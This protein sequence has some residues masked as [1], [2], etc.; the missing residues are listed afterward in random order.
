MSA[1][2]RNPHHA[3]ALADFYADRDPADVLDTIP[4]AAFYV[5]AEDSCMSGWGPCDGRDGRPWSNWVVLPCA[6]HNE[7][8]RVLTYAKSRGEMKRAR[9]VRN[10]PRQRRGVLMSVLTR[11]DAREWFAGEE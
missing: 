4:P 7:A 10:V 9:I 8:R 1:I 6:D 2:V 11:A 3:A 5:V